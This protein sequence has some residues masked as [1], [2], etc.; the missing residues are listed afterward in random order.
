ME[1]DKGFVGWLIL[2]VVALAFLKYFLDWDIFAAASSEKGRATIDY[3][4][5][6]LSVVWSYLRIPILFVWERVLELLP[7]K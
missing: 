5:E 4:L 2:I 3:T 6:V 7:S 1:K